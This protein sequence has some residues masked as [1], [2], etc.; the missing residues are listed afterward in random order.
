MLASKLGSEEEKRQFMKNILN[1]IKA[2]CEGLEDN[3]II[4]AYIDDNTEDHPSFG[5]IFYKYLNEN[6]INS[7]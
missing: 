3:G 2:F 4:E 7:H 5:Q 6:R 1:L